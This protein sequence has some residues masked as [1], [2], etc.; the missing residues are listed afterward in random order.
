MENRRNEIEEFLE[1]VHNDRY[2]TWAYYKPIV[3]KKEVNRMTQSF[4]NPARKKP[5]NE[6][7]PELNK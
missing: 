3:Q 2:Q 5:S 7:N 6:I 1:R 4:R